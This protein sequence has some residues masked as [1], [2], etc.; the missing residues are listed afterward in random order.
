MQ[1]F[2]ITPTMIVFPRMLSYTV[3]R[4]DQR[5]NARAYIAV[6]AA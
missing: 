1:F 4:T 5:P 2:F 3:I 6:A